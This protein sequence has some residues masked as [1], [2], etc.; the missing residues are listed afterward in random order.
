MN[1]SA[2]GAARP[3]Q[4]PGAGTS[5]P[6]RAALGAGASR[7]SRARLGALLVLA[8]V[9]VF[10]VA[11][12]VTLSTADT[13]Y[14]WYQNMVSDLGDGACRV[15]GGRWICSPNHVLFNT[16]L[17]L[18]GVLLAAAGACLVE[19]WG[20]VLAGGVVVMGAGLVATGVF[21]AGNRA[22]LHLTAVVLALV[23]PALGFLLSGIR[24]GTPWLHRRRGAR[25]VLASVALVF[26]A[27]SRLPDGTVPRGAGELVIVGALLLALVL[28][29][30]SVLVGRDRAVGVSR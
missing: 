26:A 22:G 29:A 11:V 21:P 15:R 25:V 18:T 2:G 3:A 9:L 23:V 24:P 28:E 30:G 27:V 7:R 17:A 10:A 13:A 4:E 8:A 14:V 5:S 20:R 16:G 6:N 12:A 1:R 19:R